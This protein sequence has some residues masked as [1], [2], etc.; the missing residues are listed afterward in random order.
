MIATGSATHFAAVRKTLV[1]WRT[2][3]DWYQIFV[4]RALTWAGSCNGCFLDHREPGMVPS[5]QRPLRLLLAFTLCMGCR[6]TF[7]HRR[8]V[9]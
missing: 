4:F 6:W 1:A 2:P 8:L 9:Q 7:H 3:L 5:N